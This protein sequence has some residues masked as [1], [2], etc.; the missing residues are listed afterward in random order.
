MCK[1]VLIAGAGLLL[2]GLLLPGIAASVF[3]SVISLEVETAPSSEYFKECP[4][5][6]GT[7]RLRKSRSG[8]PCRSHPGIFST[9]PPI[10]CAQHCDGHCIGRYRIRNGLLVP[11][12]C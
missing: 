8:Q 4:S 11:M 12:Q 1:K 5:F 2:V 3:Q 6:A 7:N 10:V 9:K